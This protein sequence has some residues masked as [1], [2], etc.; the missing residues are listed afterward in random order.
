M[1]SEFEVLK[2]RN[3][4]PV[5]LTRDSVCMA[6]DY[7]A[8]HQSSVEEYSFLDPVAFSQAISSG[9]L[10]RVAGVGHSWTCV[11]NG[12]SIA[13]INISGTRAL[14]RVT[15]FGGENKVHFVYNSSLY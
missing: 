5:V 3:R 9:Y 15:P 8:P 2:G 14:V 13:E 10:P 6:D 11:L 7:D 1:K 4:I 12:V